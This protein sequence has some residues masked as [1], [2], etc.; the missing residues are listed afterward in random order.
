MDRL[1][2]QA[3]GTICS[4][5]HCHILFSPF[6]YSCF[7]HYLI[8]IAVCSLPQIHFFWPDACKRPKHMTEEEHDLTLELCWALTSS[9]L[10]TI[11]LNWNTKFK[12]GFL[13]KCHLWVSE[14]NV[15]ECLF[16]KKCIYCSRGTSAMLMLI[17]LEWEVR[18]SGT[19]ILLA[20]YRQSTVLWHI[21]AKVLNHPLFLYI[22]LSRNLTFCFCNAVY[23]TKKNHLTCKHDSV[24]NG[25]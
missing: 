20:Y 11:G 22:L 2:V 14:H 12:P 6:L 1:A 15:V 18:W 25:H 4:G 24:R 21:I 8:W 23:S 16:K 9:P 19:H 17:V 3:R 5:N 7:V 13:V 10:D